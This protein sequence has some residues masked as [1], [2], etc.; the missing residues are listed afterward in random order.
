ML[1]RSFQG[2][3]SSSAAITGENGFLQA[4]YA[5]VKAA[6]SDADCVAR[7]FITGVSSVSLD[8]LT[9]GFNIALNVTSEGC[10]NEYAGFTEE[11]LIE[12]IPQIVDIR[13]LGVSAAEIADRMRPVYDGYRFS[14]EA[15]RTVFN[16]SMCLFYLRKVQQKGRLLPPEEHLDPA[17]DLDGSKLRQLFDIAEMDLAD[18]IIDTYLSGGR[19]L[20]KDLAENISLNK[21]DRYNRGQLLSVLYYLGYLTIDPEP[22]PDGRL[23]LRIPNLFM[24]RLFAQCTSDMRFRS[25]KEFTDPVLDI[26]AL[27]DLKD[28]IASFASSCTEFLSGICTNQVLTH[29]S[30]MAL[31]LALYTKLD[32]MRTVY[33]EMQKSLRVVGEGEQ[34]ADLVITVNADSPSEC[35]YL[36]E[37]KYVG[38][39]QATQSKIRSLVREAREQVL[40]YRSALEFRNRQIRAYAMIFAGSDC[41]CCQMQE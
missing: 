5:A 4:F 39:T 15:G 31:N 22:V 38:K 24:S 30:E 32:S 40:G 41:V 13:Q 9:S 37:L 6:A 27:L 36:I 3:S 12:L 20:L 16:S 7:T 11:E 8:S 18:E 17:S 1:T 34:Y 2:M 26:S 29:M 25:R 10:F 21:D 23:A 33:V 19:F 28:D 35:T 14:L